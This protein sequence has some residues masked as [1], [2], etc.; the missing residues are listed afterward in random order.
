M[1]LIE[2]LFEPPEAGNQKASLASLS[3]YLHLFGH[4]EGTLVWGAS[5]LFGMMAA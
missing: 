1:A 3:P 2:S 5:L 4:L